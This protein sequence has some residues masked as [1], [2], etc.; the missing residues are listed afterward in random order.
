MTCQQFNMV[1]FQ[2]T[3][4]NRRRV[5]QA[6]R[7]AAKAAREASCEILEERTQRQLRD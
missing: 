7:R 6:I 3:L 4:E 2:L 1:T 5:A